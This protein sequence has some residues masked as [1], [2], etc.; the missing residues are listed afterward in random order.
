MRI[1]DKR[2]THTAAYFSTRGRKAGSARRA[3]SDGSWRSPSFSP[4]N[5]SLVDNSNNHHM[6]MKSAIT[7]SNNELK[8]GRLEASLEVRVVEYERISGPRSLKSRPLFV[9][10]SLLLRATKRATEWTQCNNCIFF[11]DCI[12]CYFILK[13]GYYNI[14]I[15]KPQHQLL[16]HQPYRAHHHE[17]E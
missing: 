16:I 4:L 12:S 13:E 11:R 6:S 5:N 8:T 2:K 9:A 3:L 1:Y 10:P 7:L 15:Y 14:Y 17:G